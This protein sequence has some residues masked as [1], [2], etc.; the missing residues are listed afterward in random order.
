MREIRCTSPGTLRQST[1]IGHR[2]MVVGCRCWRC[3]GCARGLRARIKAYAIAGKPDKF[4]TLTVSPIQYEDE[5]EAARALRKALVHL[6][7]WIARSKRTDAIHYLAVF[8]KHKS[9]WPHLHVLARFPYIKHSTLLRRWRKLIGRG[10][11]NI[12]RPRTTEG[13]A[14][15][16]AKYVSKAGEKFDGVRRW[17]MTRGYT[18]RIKREPREYPWATSPWR[19]EVASLDTLRRT[20]A[21][22]GWVEI[23]EANSLLFVSPIGAERLMRPRRW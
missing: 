4:L 2:I 15:Y 12:K 3:D 18:A 8:E 16:V 14:R 5:H 11:L 22:N 21:R 13:V 19:R 9:G 1:D 23:E 7:Q 20:F 17:W 6:M 10:G